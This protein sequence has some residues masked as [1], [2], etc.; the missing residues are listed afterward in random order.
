MNAE[1]MIAATVTTGLLDCIVAAGGDPDQILRKAGVQR[2]LLAK[3]DGF[4]ATLAFA[5][6]L[7][8]AGRATG[9]EC[10]GL[11]FGEQFDPT[12]AGALFYVVLN[13][14]TMLAAFENWV[15]YEHIHNRGATFRFR[16]EGDLGY[17][18]YVLGD[19]GI[20][21]RRQQNEFSMAAGIKSLRIIVG[22]HW[23]PHSIE[24]AHEAPAEISEHARVFGCGI[25]FGCLWNALIFKKE[26]LDRSLPVADAKLYGILKQHVERVLSELP[27]ETDLLASVSRA[28][29]E[30]LADGPPNLERVASRF[31]VSPRSLERRLNER[32]VSFK[33]LVSEMRKR[34]ALEYLTSDRHTLTDIAFLLGY[35]E[36]SAF[37]RAF[38]RWTGSS[39]L[40]YRLGAS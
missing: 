26:D 25:K 29:V 9:D 2:S 27:Q 11:H 28:I 33:E 32:G 13:S 6:I 14:P 1:P 30:C 36:V 10:F 17:L 37:N 7:T 39:P 18:R 8:E 38:K 15:R 4:I 22:P 23:T 31:A 5:R 12:D 16:I 35:S 20:D 40:R 19:F 3:R 21:S 24:F 34:L